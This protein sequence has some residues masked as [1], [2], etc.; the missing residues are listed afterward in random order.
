M[1]MDTQVILITTKLE[2]GFRKN[3]FQNIIKYILIKMF[4]KV[5]LLN[6]DRDTQKLELMNERLN[7]INLKYTRF[8]AVDGKSISHIYDAKTNKYKRIL[9]LQDDVFFSKQFHQKLSELDLEKDIIWLGGNQTNWK[10]VKMNRENNHFWY[11]PDNHT[12][13][14]FAIIIRDTVYDELLYLYSLEEMVTDKILNKVAQEHN[15]SVIYPPLCIP[16]VS[17]SDSGMGNRE[18]SQFYNE[19]MWTTDTENYYI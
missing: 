4:D 8:P 10:K 6:L 18:N 17:T 1:T 9:I 14:E 5:Y 12:V 19:R 16:D 13:G 7:Q 11:K 3:I 2:I 15:S